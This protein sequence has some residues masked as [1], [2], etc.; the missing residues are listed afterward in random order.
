VRFV[1][2]KISQLSRSGAG[3]ANPSRAVIPG[4]GTDVLQ[5]EHHRDP[6][7]FRALFCSTAEPFRSS[8]SSNCKTNPAA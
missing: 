2:R 6:D 7:F 3:W 1:R 4:V 5:L 8:R